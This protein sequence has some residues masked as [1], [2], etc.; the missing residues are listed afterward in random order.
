MF[1]I[2]VEFF[3]VSLESGW[4]AKYAN[5]SSIL[6]TASSPFSAMSTSIPARVSNVMASFWLILLSSTRRTRTGLGEVMLEFKF[7]WGWLVRGNVLEDGEEEC[8]WLAE[9]S[10][11]AARLR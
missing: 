8:G 5:H 6:C 1:D 9:L 3:G 2:I 7:V 10:E 11:V 4:V